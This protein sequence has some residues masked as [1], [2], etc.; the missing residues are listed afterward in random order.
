[1]FRGFNVYPLAGESNQERQ[2]LISLA[3]GDGACYIPGNAGEPNTQLGLYLPRL[4]SISK[5]PREAQA[6]VFVFA[7]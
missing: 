6:E 3:L 7:S 4:A 2:P 5:S 1:L